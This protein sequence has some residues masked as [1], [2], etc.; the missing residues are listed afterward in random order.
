MDIE[1]LAREAGCFNQPD[2]FKRDWPDQYADRIE[3]QKRF[4]ALVLEEAAMVCD[5]EEDIYTA[6]GLD[7]K[8]RAVSGIAEQLRHQS[9]Q[10]S[11]PTTPT[12][13]HSNGWTD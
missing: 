6:Y 2:Q 7:Q 12:Q 9:R 11:R 4:A 3:R 10:L 5:R 13:E 1:K 8:A